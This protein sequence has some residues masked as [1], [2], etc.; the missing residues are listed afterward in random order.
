MSTIREK[1]AQLSS[2]PSYLIKIALSETHKSDPDLKWVTGK[3]EFK[4]L[5]KLLSAKNPKTEF[6]EALQIFLNKNKRVIVNSFL[7][8]DATNEEIVEWLGI[9][10][11]VIECYTKFFF[12]KEVITSKLDALAYINSIQD[13]D[14]REK[15]KYA[16][17]FGKDFVKWR[18]CGDA[19]PLINVKEELRQLFTL[20]KFNAQVASMNPI[21]GEPSK[22]A[23]KWF[24]QATKIT[25]ILQKLEA[26]KALQGAL[27]E[28]EEGD[29]ESAGAMNVIG[30]LV[31]VK[32]S[33]DVSSLSDLNKDEVG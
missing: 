8:V 3:A 28:G 14:E 10:N 29:G 33:N 12:V 16:T 31:G 7:L 11:D 1:T 6:K 26:N 22:E 20:A 17:S 27:E 21:T 2:D 23:L 5:K 32:Q 24:N 4:E 9:E 18:V 15:Y 25:D 13:E 30:V 19:V